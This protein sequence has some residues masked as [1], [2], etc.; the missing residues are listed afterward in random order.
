M[1]TWRPSD[2]LG[3]LSRALSSCSRQRPGGGYE[4]D[5][6]QGRGLPDRGRQKAGRAP[7]R[8]PAMSTRRSSRLDAVRER[9]RE[10]LRPPTF[11]PRMAARRILRSAARSRMAT[12]HKRAAGRAER[13]LRVRLRHQQCGSAAVPLLRRDRRRCEERPGHGLCHS[14]APQ[15]K[16]RSLPSRARR[17]QP[18]G[19]ATQH[20]RRQKRARRIG[21]RR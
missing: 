20:D 5:D 11:A 3:G 15:E 9:H 13:S 2:G 17:L 16:P 7:A 21:K 4:H 12:F 10:C 19:K 14:I 18:V 6:D 1:S 8:N